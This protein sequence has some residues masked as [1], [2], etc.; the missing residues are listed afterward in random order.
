MVMGREGRPGRQA[1]ALEGGVSFC[2]GT[3]CPLGSAG[4][5]GSFL[6]AA[7]AVAAEVPWVLPASWRP[8]A[9]RLGKL[10]RVYVA[11]SGLST[12]LQRQSHYHSTFLLLVDTRTGGTALGE[13]LAGS[14]S[15]LP[16]LLLGA[17]SVHPSA[18]GMLLAPGCAFAGSCLHRRRGLTPPPAPA[19]Q[20]LLPFGVQRACRRCKL[21]QACE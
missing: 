7:P 3:P 21:V 16:L 19:P 11:S 13:A 20:G 4:S 1:C 9:P 8:G 10:D 18:A 6:Q 12:S 5:V 15:L 2:A 17:P 14:C